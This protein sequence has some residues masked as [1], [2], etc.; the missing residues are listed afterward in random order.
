[1]Q[2]R[3]KIRWAL[4][5]V[6]SLCLGGIGY[7][8]YR[9]VAA[10]GEKSIDG[11]AL[12]GMLPE[13]VQWIQDFHR[14]EIKDGRKVW[15]VEGD[16]AQYLE[17]TGTVLVRAPRASMFMKDGDEVTVKGGQG[18]LKFVGKDLEEVVLRDDVEIHFR[19]FVVRA[20]SATYHR[21]SQK[22]IA[23]GAVSIVGERLEV[24][25]TNMVVYVDDRR[26]QLRRN[27]RVDMLPKERAKR[28]T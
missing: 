2:R 11:T 26:F 13:A 8:V 3:R 12:D 25:G 18:T 1:M 14:I 9:N 7:Q 24:Q 17:D 28:K 27:V 21:K 20:P 22:I 19:D 4:A 5:V 23:R 16:E 15:E 10:Q 6:V